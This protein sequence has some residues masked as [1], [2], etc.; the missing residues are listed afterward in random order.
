M[1]SFFSDITPPVLRCPENITSFTDD[2]LH[3]AT[4]NMTMPISQGIFSIFIYASLGLF[5]E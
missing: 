2:G 5:R 1:L 4:I 3:Y